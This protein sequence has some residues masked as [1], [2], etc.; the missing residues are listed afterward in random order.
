MKPIEPFPKFPKDDA[1]TIRKLTDLHRELAVVVNELYETVMARATHSPAITA[2]TLVKTGK[3]TYRGFTITVGTAAG[4][5]DIRDGV[6][7]GGGVVIDTIPATTAAGTRIEKLVGVM[8]NDGIYVDYNAGPA[9]G[10]VIVHY[11]T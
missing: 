5:I 9:T 1:Q 4:T 7:A 11:E 3:C 8:C 10:T 2:D 6:A